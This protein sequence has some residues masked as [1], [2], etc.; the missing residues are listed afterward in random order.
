MVAAAMLL[1]PMV[2]VA[3]VIVV[4]VAELAVAAVVVVVVVTEVASVQE[5]VLVGV[6]EV[7]V[8]VSL[9]SVLVVVA[10]LLVVVVG[11]L[12]ARSLVVAVAALAVVVLVAA[13]VGAVGIV[14]VEGGLVVV[15]VSTVGGVAVVAVVSELRH[16]VASMAAVVES[17]VVELVAVVAADLLVVAAVAS[18]PPPNHLQL[19]FR[20]HLPDHR[21][22]H[23]P[24]HRRSL[25]GHP[26]PGSIPRREQRGYSGHRD[27]TAILEATLVRN[28]L[29]GQVGCIIQEDYGGQGGY[30]GLGGCIVQGGYCCQEAALFRE[31][32]VGWEGNGKLLWAGK[33]TVRE[34]TKVRKAAVYREATVVREA[35]KVRKAA[36]YREATVVR[37][38]YGQGGSD[39]E[40]TK[41]NVDLT[42]SLIFGQPTFFIN[43]EK[44]TTNAFRTVAPRQRGDGHQNVT[45]VNTVELGVID[46]INYPC[47]DEGH[48]SKPRGDFELDNE[49]H[50]KPPQKFEDAEL[51]A[52]LDEDST[53]MQEKLAKQLQVSQGAVS[54]RLNSLGMTQ[55][56]SRWVPPRVERKAAITASAILRAKSR[57]A[58]P[59][60]FQNRRLG[61]IASEKKAM[62]CIWWDQTGVVYFELLKPG[63]M[64]NTSRYEQQMH[65][66]REALNEKRPEWR[67]KHNNLILQHDNAPAHNATVVKTP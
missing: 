45:L 22:V 59:A 19:G 43:Q 60:N 66:L 12:V 58:C 1:E 8:E 34:A 26:S 42:C 4:V 50:G 49:P 40:D 17:L 33:A 64:V 7:L 53:Q 36:V 23:L 56:L 52:L 16:A 51:Q 15:A 27:V 57:G 3:V 21:P 5:S 67:E 9:V 37:E 32:T 61:P 46:R 25:H 24:D 35:T 48:R 39:G 18:R 14:V 10:G 38:G 30:C 6:L 13:V 28:A 41:L 2:V 31:A 44:L 54:L 65:S 20:G 29:S 55:K 62:L 63:K 47:T 11:L